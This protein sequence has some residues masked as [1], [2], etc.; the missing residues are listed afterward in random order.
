MKHLFLL[1]WKCCLDSSTDIVDL[2]TTLET[3]LGILILTF[4]GKNVIVY[5]KEDNSPN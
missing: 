1:Q 3:Y 5:L 2:V 4:D